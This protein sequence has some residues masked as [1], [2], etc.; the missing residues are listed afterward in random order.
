MPLYEWTCEDCAAVTERLAAIGSGPP[1][2]GC[3][4]CGGP[5]RRRWSRVAVRYGAW[6]FQATDGLV[7]D[8]RGKDFRGLRERAERISDESR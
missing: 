2:T 1:D 4:A 5:L 8:T 6:G 3:D 7:R